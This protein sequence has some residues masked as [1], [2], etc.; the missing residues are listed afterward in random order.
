MWN[1]VSAN[2]IIDKRL[3]QEA[4]RK[5]LRA[6]NTIKSSLNNKTPE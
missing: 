1:L 3:K 4:H 6:L 5:H 2:R